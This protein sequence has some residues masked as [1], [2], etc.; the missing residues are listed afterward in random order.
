[1]IR[2]V[3]LALFLT[4][5]IASAVIC[6]TVDAEGGVSYAD[7]PAAECPQAVKLP[8]YSRYAP[9]PIQQPAKRAAEATGSV[10]RFERYTSMTIVQPQ[11]G[12]TVRSNEGKVPVSIAL[13]PAL[14]QGH[15][16]QLFLDG[17][18]VSGSFDAPAIELAGVDRGSHNLQARVV[19]GS[20][21]RLIESP[22][23]RFTLRKIGLNDPANQPEPT[24]PVEPPP[25]YPAAPPPNY[26]PS[27]VPDYTPQT[28]PVPS[29]PGKT[30]PAFAPKFTP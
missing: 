12:G 7:L 16:V 14:Q 13:E 1:M 23:V 30:N 8:D 3:L 2:S 17:R 24:P 21:R 9:R 6:K 29:T 18:A 26:R 4:P 5:G 15:S 10:V 19:D 22:S 27:T 28:T 20:G 11:A 25:G